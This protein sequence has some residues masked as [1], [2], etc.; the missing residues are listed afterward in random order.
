MK[1]CTFS[2]VPLSIEKGSEHLLLTFIT[3]VFPTLA[4]FFI[5]AFLFFVACVYG[6]LGVVLDHLQNLGF[7][8]VRTSSTGSQYDGVL[9]IFSLSSLWLPERAVE[10]AS[11][12]VVLQFQYGS[13]LKLVH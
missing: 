8:V 11:S 13:L 10:I 1:C 4:T 5:E 3:F 12:P 9:W 6:F 2:T 7:L